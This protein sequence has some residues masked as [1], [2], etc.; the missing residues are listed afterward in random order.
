MMP[1]T[2]LPLLLLSGW[3]PL[4]AQDAQDWKARAISSVMDYR[5]SV[6]GDTA[7]KFDGCTVVRH[8]GDTAPFTPQIAEPVRWM[9]K[10]CE[11]AR[12][13]HTVLVDSLAR[14]EAGD[15]MVYLTVIRGEW[16]HREDYALVFHDSPGSF[17][18]VREARLWGAV[19]SYPRRPTPG[20]PPD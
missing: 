14:R 5:A 12:D 2:L 11:G 13:R 19:Q 6:L 10:P 3:P 8:L 18:A 7:A 1:R 17:M 9:L 15:V 4:H 16:I 20:S